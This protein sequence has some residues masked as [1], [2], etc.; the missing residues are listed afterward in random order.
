MRDVIFLNK[1][2]T[3]LHVDVHF[4]LRTAHVSLVN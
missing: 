4:L 3:V 2:C 1:N